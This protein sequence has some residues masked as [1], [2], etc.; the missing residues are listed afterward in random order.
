[1][2]T[3]IKNDRSGDDNDEDELNE[4]FSDSVSFAAEFQLNTLDPVA[5]LMDELKH[6]DTAIRV[7]AMSHLTQIADS[8][9][10]ERSRTE[11]IP[12]LQSGCLEEEDE[13]LLVLAKQLATLSDQLGGSEYAYL[14]IKSLGNL[15][16]EEDLLVRQTAIESLLSIC[17]LL[18][19]E[20]ISLH[21]VPLISSLAEMEWFPKIQSAIILG[22]KLIPFMKLSER[23]TVFDRIVMFLNHDLSVVR[24][25]VSENLPFLISYWISINYNLKELPNAGNDSVK[26]KII[27]KTSENSSFWNKIVQNVTAVCQDRMDSVRM[28]SVHSIAVLIPIQ[29]LCLDLIPLLIEL[30][31]DESWRVKY[32][33]AEKF[34]YLLPLFNFEP[35]EMT[36][37]VKHFV[38]LCNDIEPEVRIVAVRQVPAVL[39]EII[40][41]HGN[42]ESLV[43]PIVSLF[44]SCLA[45]DNNER[46]KIETARVISDVCKLIGAD[47]V[48]KFAILPVYHRLLEDSSDVRLAMLE[49]LSSLH[50]AIGIEKIVNV[51][52]QAL[53]N[54]SLDTQWR[55]RMAFVEFL[56]SI[57]EFLGMQF[58]DSSLSDLLLRALGDHVWSVRE[59]A[60]DAFSKLINLFG[61]EWTASSVKLYLK[62]LSSHSNYLFRGTALAAINRVAHIVDPLVF[63]QSVL[64]ALLQ[65]MDDPIPNV[66]IAAC[67]CFGNVRQRL[68]NDSSFLIGKLSALSL[69]DLDE[70]VKYFATQ[71]LTKINV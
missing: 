59:A 20:A 66:R 18:N 58:F 48:E 70:D 38:K 64:P 32:V 29:S 33:L 53:S 52:L 24:K 10:P 60:L 27:Y 1:M 61:P 63:E 22:T 56:P 14:L 19:E 3:L 11:L 57:A 35:F 13:V 31:N 43:S 26:D 25:T 7:N 15:A 67:K 17:E 6:Q 37:F 65:L 23:E 69:N 44:T 16:G 49:N 4:E 9:G 47:F 54:L 30:L 34:N 5:L 62:F 39:E 2:T 71:S 28:F 50:K 41:N 36:D 45:E 55:V 21:V 8:L 46:V 68:S 51:L 42:I 40:R 12:F